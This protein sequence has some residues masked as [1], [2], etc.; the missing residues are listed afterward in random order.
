MLVRRVVEH[1]VQQDS[2]PSLVGL[3]QKRLE[4]AEGANARVHSA[5]VNDV[6]PIVPSAGGVKGQQPKAVNAQVL[7]VAQ[8]LA[9]PFEVTPS[10]AVR[11][12]VGLHLNSVDHRLPV[13][14]TSVL[15]GHT[16]ASSHRC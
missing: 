9:Q 2:Y 4:F 8:L 15:S 12:M 1:E 14:W 11:V 6:V 10:I 5:V 13:P 16:S 7:E 3:L